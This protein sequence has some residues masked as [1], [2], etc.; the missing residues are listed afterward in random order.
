MI[1]VATLDSWVAKLGYDA[2]PEGESTLRLV[3][4]TPPPHPVP[5]FF[6]QVSDNWVL[7][8]MLPMLAHGAYRAEDLGRRL[9][10]E[11]RE[12]KVAK[13]ALDTDGAV[14]LCAELPTE[15]LQASEVADAVAR[16][17]QYARRFHE[18]FVKRS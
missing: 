18:E 7:F 15:S 6:V 17:A 12:M 16:M 5:P 8:S 11:N 13:F 4:R 9:L 1:D 10:M 2:V 3:P 14:V